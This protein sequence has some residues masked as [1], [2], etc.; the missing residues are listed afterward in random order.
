MS[1]V[2][3]KTDWASSDVIATTDL[4][5]IE[6]N[7]NILRNTIELSSA[8]PSVSADRPYNL[9]NTMISIAAGK[10]LILRRWRCYAYHLSGAVL[11]KVSIS[12]ET[13]YQAVAADTETT[14]DFDLYVNTAGTTQV[15]KLV[16]EVDSGDSGQW[17]PGNGWH[18]TLEII[19]TP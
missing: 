8:F 18:L 11:P 5:R 1:W 17:T 16:V 13:K 10:T 9:Y 6:E 3:P 2:A 7:E 4:I 19:D 14:P 12:G 15:K